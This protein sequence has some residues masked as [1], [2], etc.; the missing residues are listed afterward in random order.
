MKAQPF[1]QE[2]VL[3]MV[4]APSDKGSRAMH[5]GVLSEW[6]EETEVRG[7]VTFL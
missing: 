7:A 4:T 5:C 6:D 2:I 1:P 3:K